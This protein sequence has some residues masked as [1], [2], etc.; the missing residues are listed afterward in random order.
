M[1]LVALLGLLVFLLAV[2]SMGLRLL[3]L[4][5]KTRELPELTLGI[6]YIAGGTLGW[7][8]TLVSFAPG[9][10]GTPAGNALRTFAVLCLSLGSMG[11]A[12]GNWRI[13]RPENRGIGIA[14]AA[15]VLV[16]GVEFVRNAVLHGTP[17]VRADDGWYWPGAIG[18]ALPYWWSTFE[19]IRYYLLMRRRLRFGLVQ[20]VMVNKFF[21]WAVSGLC[22]S[23][24][25]ALAVAGTVFDF[26]YSHASVVL[27]AYGALGALSAFSIWLAFFPPARY[28]R[29]VEAHAD[30][31]AA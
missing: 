17:F 26:E 5:T 31:A 12:I 13:Y 24:T 8:L 20:P 3:W 18:R 6:A 9:L 1:Q 28:L 7:T 25:C 30:G 21:L 16:L 10:L 23:T 11:V 14:C 27:S 2:T 29:F 4:W 15:L 19:T 22:G